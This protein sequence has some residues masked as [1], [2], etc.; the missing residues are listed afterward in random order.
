MQRA[1]ALPFLTLLCLRARFGSRRTFGSDEFRPLPEG[2]V[3]L[4]D[5]AEIDVLVLHGRDLSGGEGFIVS[6]HGK[7][8]SPSTIR[9][10]TLRTVTQNAAHV[11]HPEAARSVVPALPTD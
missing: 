6:V 2:L 1:R 4:G 11:V 9:A 3:Q 5:V 7:P 10:F 8:A